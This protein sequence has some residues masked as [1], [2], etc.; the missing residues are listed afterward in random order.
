MH[1]ATARQD[2][3]GIGLATRPR[4]ID[5]LVRAMAAAALLV[6]AWP[7]LAPDGPVA[8]DGPAEETAADPPAVS[9]GGRSGMLAGREVQAGA[10]GGV[11]YTQPSA[12][13]IENPGR[14]DLRVDPVNWIGRP[15]KSPIYYGARLLSWWPSSFFGAMVDFTHAK[16]IAVFSDEA[17]FSGTRNGRTLSAKAKVGEVFRHL[18]FSHGHN[19]LTLNGMARLGTFFGRLRP[20]V[21]AGGGVALPHT[22]IGFAG[23]KERTYEYQYA[24]LAW[25]ALAGVEVRLGR[26]S[27][28]FEYKFTFAPY[29]VPLSQT[30]NGWLLVT[31]LWR[32]LQ[33]WL[34][35]MPPPDGTLRTTLITHHAVSGVLLNA[36]GRR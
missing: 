4:S 22:E 29:S 14:T 3:T 33:A 1:I 18:E 23:E 20:Y 17:A 35:G 21:G 31:D 24:G 2:A 13:T 9:D 30:Q 10:Y 16:A 36:G 5:G 32:Q 11:T 8:T 28:F 34:A 6:F 19:L 15:F 27:L 25:Q 26:V 12:V 7:V